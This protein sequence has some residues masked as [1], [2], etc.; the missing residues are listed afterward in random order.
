MQIEIASLEDISTIRDIAYRTW[1]SAYKEILSV[2]Q[3]N[4]MLE[5]M[6]NPQTLENQFINPDYHFLLSKENDIITGFASYSYLQEFDLYKLHKLY[7]LPENQSKGHGKH[8]IEYIINHLQ[9][10]KANRLWLNVNRNNKAVEFYLK[11][12]FTIIKEEDIDI[13]NGYFMND[14]VMEK[15]IG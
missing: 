15:W 14:Y 7:V 13:G 2:E 4:Y 3:L 6:Y 8:L 12:G 10:I 9:S 5:M 1:P 11:R